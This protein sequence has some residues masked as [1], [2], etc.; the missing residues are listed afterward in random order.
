MW[1]AAA[2]LTFMRFLPKMKAR[3][4][5][6]L[7]MFI[8]TFCLVSVSAYRDDEIIRMALKRLTTVMIGSC[9][10]LVMCICVW[11]AWIGV[12]LH[13]QIA[14]NLE[15]LGIFLEGKYI[16]T[17]MPFQHTHIRIYVQ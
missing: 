11:P 13:N 3:Y 2:I 6:G 10:S 9:A 17:H 4:D 8:L 16:Y 5:Y 15:K 7:M 14:T 1:L 12:D